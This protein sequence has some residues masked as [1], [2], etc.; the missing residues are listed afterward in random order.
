MVDAT[1][2]NIPTPNSAPRAGITEE[3]IHQVVHGFYARVS[4]DPILSPIFNGVIQNEDWPEHLEKMCDFWSSVLLMT[5]RFKG[6]PMAAHARIQ[7]IQPM[8]FAH[9]LRLFRETVKAQCPPK[10]AELFIAKSEMIAKSL[11]HGIGL[12]SVKYNVT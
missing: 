5:R 7:E 12:T 9:W 10:E 2:D 4:K 3:M 6:A 8:H 11:Q 1:N